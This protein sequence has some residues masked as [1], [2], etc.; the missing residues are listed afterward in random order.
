[1]VATRRST[2][3]SIVE[4]PVALRKSPRTISRRTLPWEASPSTISSTIKVKTTGPEK[5]FFRRKS[6]EKK[7]AV[8]KKTKKQPVC[9]QGEDEDDDTPV[10]QTFKSDVQL[11]DGLSVV[12]D[13]GGGRYEIVNL[14]TASVNRFASEKVGIEIQSDENRLAIIEGL[15][16]KQWTTAKENC[17]QAKRSASKLWQP[18]PQN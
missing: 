16:E 5:L 4:K 1:M 12:R 18:T 3:K 13:L 14:T 7:T 6:A 9:L 11:Q 8:K 15:D 10:F 2:A 17:L